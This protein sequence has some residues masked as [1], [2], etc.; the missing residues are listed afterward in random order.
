MSKGKGPVTRVS[1]KPMCEERMTLNVSETN[2]VYNGE[3]N[4]N[5]NK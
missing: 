1:H 2:D 5:K 3:N 4:N